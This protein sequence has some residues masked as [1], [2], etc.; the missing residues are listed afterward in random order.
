Y[1]AKGEFSPQTLDRAIRYAVRNAEAVRLAKES[2]SLLK[3]AQ[4]AAGVGA[5]EWD[6]TNSTFIWS[7]RVREIFGV[8]RD[9]KIT[10]GLW[11]S[12][13]HP[14][15]RD[16]AQA[17]VAAA[18]GGHA[19]FDVVYRI[20]RADPSNPQ[21]TP[22]LRW[23][24]AKGEV[25]RDANGTPL[26]MVGIHMDVTDQ[27]TAI[28]ALQSSREAARIDLQ[29][30]EARFQTY[31]EASPECLFHLR[32]D[33]D[34]QFRYE[35]VNPA[36]LAYAGTSLERLRGRTPVEVLGP[37]A[38]DQVTA[39]LQE[40]LRTGQPYRYEPTFE[41]PAGPVIFDAVY[42]P[43]RDRAGAITGVLGSAR[44]I[45]ER[46][47]LEEH[48]HRAKKM[49]ALG[50]LASGVAHDFNNLLTGIL[51]CFELLG[52]QVKSERAQKLIVQGCRAVERSTALTARLLAF[53]RHQ[54]LSTQTVDVN[55]S[56]EETVEM[57]ARTLGADIRI[58]TDFAPDLWK[59]ST[60]RN[61][62]E[63][64]IL[65]LGINARDAMPLGGSLTISTRNETLVEPGDAMPPGE[66]IA[67]AVTDTGSGMPP[68]V[69]KRVMEPFFT[70]KGPGKGTGLGLSMVAGVTRQLG[71]GLTITSEPGKGT[72]VTLYLPRAPHTA[73]AQGDDGPGTIP[74]VRIL[75]VD[76][77]PNV[78][79]V[80][81]LYAADAGHQV[82]E[83][84][85]ATQ[86]LTLLDAGHQ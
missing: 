71:G 47:R 10:Y 84:T 61:Q 53:S 2:A 83:A 81:A 27:Q 23:V 72:C 22:V 40:V 13:V 58:G 73:P 11:L 62:V 36:G 35:T 33:P 38:G 41:L 46:H 64:A 19:P 56:L 37:Q 43:L 55:G 3:M 70:T 39:A 6:V 12:T 16:A 1:L 29:A 77:D 59:A 18:V 5:W 54:P 4:E 26:R 34:G 31:F 48:L 65:N 67:V 14:E 45:T 21:G 57:L 82:L 76:D 69:L 60:D 51:G 17:A 74:P 30:S 78:Q 80:V 85:T 24:S 8:D 9:A 86:A 49:E 20:L 32:A 68:D 66:Y 25:V 7:A 42:M 28:A 63:L 44:D 15:D 52:R 50:Q 75:L 79:A